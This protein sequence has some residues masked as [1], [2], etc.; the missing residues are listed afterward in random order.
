MNTYKK[1]RE[2]YLFSIVI[3]VIV[4]LFLKWKGVL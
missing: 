1:S 3:I 2:I 4:V